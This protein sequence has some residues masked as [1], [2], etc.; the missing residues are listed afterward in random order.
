MFIKYSVLL[1]SL[2][3]LSAVNSENNV[4]VSYLQIWF[5]RLVFLLNIFMIYC[6]IIYETFSCFLWYFWKFYSVFLIY[7]R[8]FFR[9]LSR[10]WIDYRNEIQF[11]PL[12]TFVRLTYD[13]FEE[14]SDHYSRVYWKL[15]LAKNLWVINFFETKL[16]IAFNHIICKFFN[17]DPKRNAKGFT[18][19]YKQW[20][21]CSKKFPQFFLNSRND[22]RNF[23]NFY[24]FN[25]LI[26]LIKLFSSFDAISIEWNYFF[27]IWWIV[28][29]KII[30]DFM[31]FHRNMIQSIESKL[32]KQLFITQLG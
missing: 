4:R 21:V 10:D 23:R 14:F 26:E 2:Y 16:I 11:N 25:R 18:F 31:H 6:S 30:K 7:S 17:E 13:R 28:E 5:Y 15:F 22:L 29:N 8:H 24:S 9:Q 3:L 12:K 27:I 19:W 32:L 20:I 1:I